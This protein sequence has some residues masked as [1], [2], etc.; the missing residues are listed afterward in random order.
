MRSKFTWDYD[1]TRVWR[2]LRGSIA[3][4]IFLCILPALAQKSGVQPKPDVIL[5]TIDTLRADHL[6]CYGYKLIQ[7]PNIDKLA[8]TGAQ[9][10]TVV[11]QVPLTFP[12]HCSILTGTYPMFHKVRDNMGYRLDDSKTTLAEILK[13][14]GYQTGAFVGSYVLDSRF[15]LGQGFDT[16][17]DHFNPEKT[18]DGLLNPG[19]LERRAEEVVN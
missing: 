1:L 12:S 6:G 9:F 11:A 8:A 4:W 18:P 19:Q 7:T 14:N 3:L 5:I 13:T 15:G 10:A 2:R 16:Y 17:Y